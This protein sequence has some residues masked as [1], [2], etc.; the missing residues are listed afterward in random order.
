MASR[1]PRAGA[2]ALT[3]ACCALAPV[4]V[5]ADRYEMHG[6]MYQD[7]EGPDNAYVYV[8]NDGR[9]NSVS[10]S[11]DNTDFRAARDVRARMHGAYLWFRVG[12]DS[13]VTQD[14]EALRTLREALAPVEELG[15]RQGEI[16][17][18][19][20]EIGRL[21]G[22]VGRLQGRIGADQGR[23]AAHEASIAMDDRERSSEKHDLDRRH[24]DLSRQ[25]NE[26]GAQMQRL[27][28]RMEPLSR[29]QSELGAQQSRASAHL[30]QVT[31]RLLPELAKSNRAEHLKD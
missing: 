16:G 4:A 22:E 14:A 26:L 30:Q 13:Y 11:G 23:L 12:N 18:K 20:G 17:R 25:M 5:R 31:D 7:H 9:D 2:A 1:F 29:Q 19:Q 24:D 21:Q 27:S 8:N 15:R 6:T 10:G 28:H 3:L